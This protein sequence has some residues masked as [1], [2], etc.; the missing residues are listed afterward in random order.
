MLL[1]WTR[2][3]FCRLVEKGYR[4][5]KC[6]YSKMHELYFTLFENIVE[7]RIKRWNS[8]FSRIITMFLGYS[9]PLKDKFNVLD[10]V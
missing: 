4:R 6:I 7:K 8:A 3:K 2:P 9:Y 10:N 5:G 1:I